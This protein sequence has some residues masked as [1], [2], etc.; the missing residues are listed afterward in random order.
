MEIVSILMGLV[1]YIAPIIILY[2]IIQLA[3]RKGID[4]SE[5]GRAIIEKHYEKSSMDNNKK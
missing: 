5:A 2:F 1:I 4:N 3:V